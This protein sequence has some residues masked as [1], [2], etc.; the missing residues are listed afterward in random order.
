VPTSTSTSAPTTATS[1]GPPSTAP[2]SAGAQSLKASPAGAA[3]TGGGSYLP[4]L[5]TGAIVIALA[6]VAA[7]RWRRRPPLP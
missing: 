2:P 1:P 7:F 6:T 3:Q 5:V 4:L